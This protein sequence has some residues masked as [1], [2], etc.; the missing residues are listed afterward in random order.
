MHPIN[1]PNLSLSNKIM[2]NVKKLIVVFALRI[3]HELCSWLSVEKWE[4]WRE[5][6]IEI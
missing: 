3:L 5:A 1:H 6:S 4:S 2:V